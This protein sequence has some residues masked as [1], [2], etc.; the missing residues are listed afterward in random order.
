MKTLVITGGTDGMGRELA[1]IDDPPAA[2][3]SAFMKS[4]PINLDHTSFSPEAAARLSDLT[5]HLLS[6]LEG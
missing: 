6:S 4:E 3:L 1:R 2:P 5:R